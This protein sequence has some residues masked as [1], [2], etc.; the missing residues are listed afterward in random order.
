MKCRASQITEADTK[1]KWLMGT[2]ASGA[3][4]DRYRGHLTAQLSGHEQTAF[5]DCG[6]LTQVSPTPCLALSCPSAFFSFFKV[7]VSV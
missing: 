1:V 2:A 7:L 5:P 6:K 3:P 4:T